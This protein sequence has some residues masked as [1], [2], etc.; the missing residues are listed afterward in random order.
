MFLYTVF[1]TCL[2]RSRTFATLTNKNMFRLKVTAH[3]Y[4]IDNR[5]WTFF[6]VKILLMKSFD[7][8]IIYFESSFCHVNSN[9]CNR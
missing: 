6:A 2:S 8:N 7:A 3:I 4:I 1:A 5:Q 9:P